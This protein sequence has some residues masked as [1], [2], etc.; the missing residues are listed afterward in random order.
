MQ[1]AMRGRSINDL[2]A[3]IETED[4][5]M[6]NGA[7]DHEERT[8]E[9]FELSPIQHL[10]FNNSS[11]KEYGDRFN[12][13][14]LLSI[15][16]SLDVS[17]FEHACCALVKRHPMLRARFKKSS[18][19][20]WT[21]QI[22]PDIDTSHSFHFHKLDARS[23]MISVLAASQKSIHISGPV[24]VVDLFERP[25]GSQAVSLIAHHLVVDIVSWINIIQDLEKFLSATNPIFSKP[26]SFRNWNRAQIEH[27]RSLDRHGDSPLPFPV[28]AADFDFWGMSKTA[29]MYGDVIKKAFIVSGSEIVSLVLGDSHK[30]LKTE[31]L[32]LFIS[33]LLKSFGNIFRERELPT[34][35]NEGHGRE[36]WDDA[37]D[38]SQTVGWFTSLSPIHVSRRNLDPDGAIDCVRTVKTCVAASQAMVVLTLP[39]AT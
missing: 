39:A 20:R 31:P 3:L 16:D 37:I 26:F 4:R 17:R 11:N 2:A 15:K 18:D 13:S 30:A 29:N 38:L 25:D 28:Q 35:F 19:G 27:A 22:A 1:E 33:A 21:Q 8:N 34:L 7:P 9:E 12:Q 24:F 36:P 5:Q 6:R 14:Q 10:F 32:D 23:D